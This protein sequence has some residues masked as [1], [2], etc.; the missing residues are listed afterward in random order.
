MRACSHSSS[1]VTGRLVGELGAFNELSSILKGVELL[2]FQEVIETHF[3]RPGD[4]V[5]LVDDVLGCDGVRERA[6]FR[7]EV[8]VPFFIVLRDPD[9]FD[10]LGDELLEFFDGVAILLFAKRS[11]WSR[12]HARYASDKLR[13]S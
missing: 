2:S 1:I 13:Y 4:E 11:P 6:A 8:V 9:A 5:R 12:R 7:V 3:D 10:F